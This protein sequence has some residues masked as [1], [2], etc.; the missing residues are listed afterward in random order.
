MKDVLMSISIMNK[1]YIITYDNVKKIT[2]ALGFR[3]NERCFYPI[4]LDEELKL[5]NSIIDNNIRKVFFEDGEISYKNQVYLKLRNRFDGKYYFTRNKQDKKI[6]DYDSNKDL[7]DFYNPK[8]IIYA[9]D[10]QDNG[11]FFGNVQNNELPNDFYNIPYKGSNNQPR[12]NLSKKVAIAVSGI[13]GAV[14]I[15]LS[16][17]TLYSQLLVPPV[18]SANQITINTEV[19]DEF[20]FPETSV[21]SVEDENLSEKEFAVK[22]KYENY[23][24]ELERQNLKPWEIA[25]V[26]SHIKQ[27]EYNDEYFANPEAKPDKIYFYYD[28]DKNDVIFVYDKFSRATLENLDRTDNEKDEF[29]YEEGSFSKKVRILVDSIKN[30]PNLSDEDKDFIINQ[31]IKKW[32][33]NED[34]I[35]EQVLSYQLKHLDIRYL[36]NEK[37]NLCVLN[38]PHTKIIGGAYHEGLNRIDIYNMMSRDHEIGHVMGNF[39]CY[40]T[41]LN[42]GYNEWKN[43]GNDSY[44]LERYM[45]YVYEEVFGEET[46]RKGYYSK[47][48]HDAI[49]DKIVQTCGVSRDEV[50]KEVSEL[51]NKTQDTLYFV[52][53]NSEKDDTIN[54]LDDPKNTQALSDLIEYIN[55]FNNRLRNPSNSKLTALCD[56]LTGRNNMGLLQNDGERIVSIK[57]LESGDMLFEIGTTKEISCSYSGTTSIPVSRFKVVRID[58]KPNS[59]EKITDIELNYPEFHT[60][61]DNDN[62]SEEG[63]DGALDSI[64]DEKMTHSI[65]GQVQEWLNSFL[66]KENNLNDR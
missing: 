59:F 45:A 10:N 54:A 3:K 14:I 11:Y 44:I 55:G 38:N 58:T 29:K 15:T 57:Y 8:N 9:Y 40:S 28:F 62:S 27:F 34:Y 60:F 7:Y 48:L 47:N 21:L 32:E 43:G 5:I 37:A 46:L 2:N 61:T 24:I 49:V 36:L 16:G 31:W 51:L 65:I 25:I 20:G 12:S 1:Y 19:V 17:M 35:D 56:C 13:V 50:E 42:E 33:K 23:K 26:L 53:E 22:Q 39:K 18:T 63:K 52:A 66:S 30:N 6:L 64:E 4:I 41:L